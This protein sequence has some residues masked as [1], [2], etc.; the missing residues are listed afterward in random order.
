MIPIRFLG[1]LPAAAGLAMVTVASLASERPATVPPAAANARSLAHQRTPLPSAPPIRFDRLFKL[2]GTWGY[3]FRALAFSQDGRTLAAT[4]FGGCKIP[5]VTLWDVGKR[6]LLHVLPHPGRDVGAIAF[7]PPGDRLVTG[8]FGT[9]KVFVW[10]V[11]SGKLLDTM[12]PEGGPSLLGVEGL[13]AFPDGNRVLCCVATGLTVWDLRARARTI[14]PLDEYVPRAPNL[15]T[16]P[17]HC[18]RVAFSA[19][20]S[21]F[22]TMVSDVCFANRILVWDA[23]TCR[24]AGII[25]VPHLQPDCAY[26]PVPH[27][28]PRLAYSPNGRTLAAVY[29]DPPAAGDVIGVWDVATG[30]ELLAGRVYDWGAHDLEYVRD[31][32]YLLAA[33]MQD[34]P[35][36]GRNAAAPRDAIGVWEVATGRLVGRIA[37]VGAM[38]HMAISPDNKLLAVPGRDIDVYAIEY[39]GESKSGSGIH[40][41]QR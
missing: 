33:G 10:E 3:G 20:G 37:P 38:T 22:A 32:K 13:A 26:A 28:Q 24:V 23:K 11:S 14:L 12:D 40:Y 17:R 19:D 16:I 34:N 36:P 4:R 7:V 39:A 18:E 25:P 6:K 31:G 27:F 35:E 8:S 1:S 9:E 29:S 41:Q 2:E 30:R 15:P 5:D 21:R